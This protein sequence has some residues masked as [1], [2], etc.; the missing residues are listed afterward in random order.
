[1]PVLCARIA[2]ACTGENPPV[3]CV[4]SPPDC[5]ET[6]PLSCPDPRGKQ[7]NCSLLFIGNWLYN[8]S[9]DQ[10]EQC[11]AI[12]GNQVIGTINVTNGMKLPP[13]AATVVMEAG[14]RSQR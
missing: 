1:M 9:L 14:P 11:N 12:Q 2:Y 13:A 7:Q 3:G 5:P 8:A 6:C 4:C 10:Q